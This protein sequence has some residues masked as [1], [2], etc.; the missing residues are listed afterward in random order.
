M[1][2]IDATKAVPKLTPEQ[3]RLKKACRDLEE[4]FMRHLVR[5]LHVT[6]SKDPSLDAAPGSDI[7]E[8]MAEEALSSTLTDAGG[9]GLADLLYRQMQGALAAEQ[10]KETAGEPEAKPVEGAKAAPVAEPPG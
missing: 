8:A 4:V 10:A 2:E 7:Y 6:G 5:E 9:I 3:A 1:P